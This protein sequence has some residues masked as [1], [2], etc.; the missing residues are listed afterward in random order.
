MSRTIS[1]SAMVVKEAPLIQDLHEVVNDITASKVNPE[2]DMGDGVFFEDGDGV[3]DTFTIVHHDSGGS[4]WGIQRRR[5]A[6]P[7]CW[8]S[9]KFQFLLFQGSWIRVLEV[10][11]FILIRSSS[12]LPL[13][14]PAALIQNYALRLLQY[15]FCVCHLRFAWW[16]TLTQ[17]HKELPH[18]W[19]KEN[20]ARSQ[21]GHCIAWQWLTNIKKTGSEALHRK[22]WQPFVLLSSSIWPSVLQTPNSQKKTQNH[23]ASRSWAGHLVKVPAW[24]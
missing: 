11:L 4:A 24:Q 10:D 20:L 23:P 22:P 9:N 16:W 8:R 7:V 17:R 18:S 15:N 3:G 19:A 14:S 5:R 6:W 13:S 21:S 12:T 1:L 2:D